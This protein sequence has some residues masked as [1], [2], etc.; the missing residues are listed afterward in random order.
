[1][2]DNDNGFSSF[3][4]LFMD[5]IDDECNKKPKI[6]FSINDSSKFGIDDVRGKNFI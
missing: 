3:T 1:M 4:S 6:L 5:I 2:C